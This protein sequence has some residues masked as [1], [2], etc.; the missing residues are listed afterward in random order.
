[1]TCVSVVL[2]VSVVVMA[3][4]SIVLLML[5]RKTPL[6][7]LIHRCTFQSLLLLLA[8]CAVAQLLVYKLLVHL[9]TGTLG[10]LT[11]GHVTVWSS[12]AISLV[13][14]HIKVVLPTD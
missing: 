7:T 11:R 9:A 10:G 3:V 6:H 14:G 5:T 12:G 13:T 8:L 2:V 4:R 1:M